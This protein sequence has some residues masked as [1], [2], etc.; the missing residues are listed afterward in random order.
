M[1]RRVTV[2]LEPRILKAVDR[3]PGASRS[4]K[5][6][7]LLGDALALQGHRRWV[8]EL[9][10]FYQS[11]AAK[12]ERRDDAAWHRLAEETLFRDD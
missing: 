11:D 1:K 12:A 5:V 7:R 10:A 4:D 6:E 2:S 9:K 3:I 8:A